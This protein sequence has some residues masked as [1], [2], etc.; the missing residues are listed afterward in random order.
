MLRSEWILKYTLRSQT[1]QLTRKRLSSDITGRRHFDIGRIIR[2]WFENDFAFIG[3]YSDTSPSRIFPP[4][5]LFLLPFLY[6]HTRESNY[7]PIT[8]SE[9]PIR[10]LFWTME[11]VSSRIAE[12]KQACGNDRT[13]RLNNFL[14]NNNFQSIEAN[15]QH[16]LIP[17]IHHRNPCSVYQETYNMDR[18]VD[19]QIIESKN[20]IHKR[21]LLLARCLRSFLTSECLMRSVSWNEYY[22]SLCF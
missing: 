21:A 4:Q 6:C 17:V 10:I 18:V 9:I 22:S 11:I 16:Y 5:F 3:T 14:H 19:N 15:W 12:S 13:H 2:F 1:W 7:L 8:Q 20:S